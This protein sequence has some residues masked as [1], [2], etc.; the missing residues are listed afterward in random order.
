MAAEII[1]KKRRTG[2]E[3]VYV[4]LSHVMPRRYK[5]TLC[6]SECCVTTSTY[7]CVVGLPAF[8]LAV[9]L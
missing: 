6:V 1:L 7:A 9:M 3:S 5:S 4:Q 2:Y 8:Q